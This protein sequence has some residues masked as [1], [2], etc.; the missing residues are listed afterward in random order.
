[1]IGC[2]RANCGCNSFTVTSMGELVDSTGGSKEIYVDV[3]LRNFSV[4]VI[5]RTCFG[6][7]FYKRKMHIV[8]AQAA[9]EGNLSS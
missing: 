1:M 8:R 7:S 2:D 3:Y 6:S 9:P 4:H 5:A